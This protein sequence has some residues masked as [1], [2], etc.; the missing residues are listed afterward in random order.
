MK[1]NRPGGKTLI[2]YADGA[3]SPKRSGAGIAACDPQGRLILLTNQILPVMNNNEAEYAGLIL[4][5]NMAAR[6][7]AGA[8]EIRLDSEIVVYQ[9]IGRFAVNSVKLK[10]HH[11]QA[12]ALARQFTNV[13]YT[14]IPRQQNKLAD[15]LASE[16][17][18]GR[19]WRSALPD[20]V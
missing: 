16:A 18:A 5:L 12:C 7:G 14:H 4:A 13:T 2:V 20:G 15:A 1:T 9:M 3:I 10:P 11:R 6:C 19:E 17:A 8:V